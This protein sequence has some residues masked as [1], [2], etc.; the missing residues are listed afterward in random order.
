MNSK[1]LEQQLENIKNQLINQKAHASEVKQE[2]GKTER[3]VQELS[4]AFQALFQVLQQTEKE[5]KAVADEA[6]KPKEE[7][8]A[9]T[10]EAK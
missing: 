6:A 1:Q 9:T 3:A 4:G 8:P 2:L 7:K 5:E 10:K